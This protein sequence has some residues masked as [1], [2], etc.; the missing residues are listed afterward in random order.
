MA[1]SF[2]I[3]CFR[4]VEWQ[5][6]RCLPTEKFIFWFSGEIPRQLCFPGPDVGMW[7]SSLYTN[8]HRLWQAASLPQEFLEILSCTPL[9]TDIPWSACGFQLQ[10][11]TGVVE[12]ACVCQLCW[13][14]LT[15]QLGNVPRRKPIDAG[16]ACCA[17]F[18][19]P[20]VI[21]PS[22]CEG[23]E[24]GGCSFGCALLHVLRQTDILILGKLDKKKLQQVVLTSS[25]CLGHIP[26]T[27]VYNLLGSTHISFTSYL[28]I[29]HLSRVQT[30]RNRNTLSG[31]GD[32]QV[33]QYCGSVNAA[34]IYYR[35]ST[36]VGSSWTVVQVSTWRILPRFFCFASD[37]KENFMVIR[38]LNWFSPAILS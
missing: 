13:C 26:Y 3:N 36:N 35:S 32:G 19:S 16:R 25:V 22:V 24:P 37:A 15:L 9:L 33:I 18:W 29:S 30:K 4:G 38:L 5:E 12:V 10:T 31:Y 20:A 7:T 17:G 34:Q 2:L 6:G 11:C 21:I 14:L 1:I 23:K 28:C 8:A 27:S